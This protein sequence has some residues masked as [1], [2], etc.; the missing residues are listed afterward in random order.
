MVT[1]FLISAFEPHSNFFV[2]GLVEVDHTGLDGANNM[3]I[4]SG[5]CH[6]VGMHYPG[7]CKN[8]ARN[9]EINANA[10]R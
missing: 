1:F 4:A 3:G 10:A 7:I 8:N 6:S 5:E 9:A 2:T